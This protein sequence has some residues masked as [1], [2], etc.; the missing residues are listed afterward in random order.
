MNKESL[1]KAILL[2]LDSLDKSD[3]PLQDKL[4]IMINI[5]H[6]L[7]VDKYDNNLKIL[8][9]ENKTVLNR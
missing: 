7:N 9:K 8:S 2:I 1:E 4:E 6:F 3:I 5:R